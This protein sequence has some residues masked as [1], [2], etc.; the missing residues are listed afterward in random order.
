MEKFLLNSDILNRDDML[1]IST[2][3][4]PFE[5]YG[6][7]MSE[8]LIVSIK[9]VTDEIKCIGLSPACIFIPF[10]QYNNFT[11]ERDKHF[12]FH[13]FGSLSDMLESLLGVKTPIICMIPDSLK[14]KCKP[15]K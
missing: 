1:F 13:K 5:V 7:E 10:A 11:V 3:K 9:K 6:F 8:D 2:N 14:D 4:C 12:P 15:T